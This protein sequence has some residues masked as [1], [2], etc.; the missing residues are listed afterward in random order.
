MTL[1]QSRKLTLIRDI[2][3][4]NAL[5][6]ELLMPVYRQM[7]YVLVDEEHGPQE[8]GKDIVLVGKDPMGDYTYTGVI[9]K[10]G[11]IS[12]ATSPKRSDT[13]ATVANQIVMTLNSGYVC[14]IQQKPVSFQKIVVVT[15]GR[16]SNSAKEE[17]LKTARQHQ[18]Q[19][20][21]FHQGQDLVR[22]VDK[23]LPD[24]Y[25][26][27]SG[28]VSAYISALKAKC[29]RLDE[30]KNISIYKGEIKRILDVFVSP[31]LYR[32]Q[33]VIKGSGVVSS[34]P[35][36][37]SFS[38]L[39][40]RQK[41]LLI[42]GGPGS[43]KSTLLRAGIQR[44]LNLNSPGKELLLPVLARMSD[45][46]TCEGD[47]LEDMLDAYIAQEYGVSDF[48]ISRFLGAEGSR[49]FLFLDGLDEVVDQN[50]RQILNEKVCDF[51][52][53][54]S[55]DRLII[56]SRE[57][58][59]LENE[60]LPEMQR[61]SLL[62]FR[63]K[64]IH[65]FISRWF[66]AD[67]PNRRVMKALEEH[68]LLRKLPNTPLVL[69]L[70][71]IMFDSASYTDV[72]ANLSELY[73]MFVDLLLGKWSLDRR[74]ETLYDANIKEYILMEIAETMHKSDRH[75]LPLSE[76]TALI[77][78]C[79]RRLAVE[80]NPDS[81]LAELTDQTGLI[82]CNDRGELEFRHLSFQEFLVARRYQNRARESVDKE[83]I[84]NFHDP[85][86]ARVVYYYCGLRREN[87]HML[88]DLGVLMRSY[89]LP[90]AL[91]STWEY[92]YLVQSSYL[93]PA[94][95]RVS[96]IIEQLRQYAS[97][98]RQLLNMQV[99]GSSISSL[100]PALLILSMTE[101]FRIYYG[102]SHMATLYA[103]V[104][105]Q[106]QAEPKTFETLL[107]MLLVA[108]ILAEYDCPDYLLDIYDDIRVEPLLL[109]AADFEIRLSLDFD[110]TPEQRGS[111]KRAVKKTRRTIASNA[112]LYRSLLTRKRAG[113]IGDAGSDKLILASGN[114]SA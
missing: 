47:T 111:L 75:G 69:T 32:I 88:S 35:V 42:V 51:A 7:G 90:G 108:S 104:F 5:R 58:S 45:L 95:V 109:L 33:K 55:R 82:A 31:T 24:Y 100:P 107:A 94:E 52:S 74:V 84:S 50:K 60:S 12:N 72:P 40:F 97:H 28:V 113:K 70:L 98:V 14:P 67:A 87:D 102:S 80:V 93:T 39:V 23:Y 89:H 41:H 78:E 10:R 64:Q 110:I 96:C 20:M 54:Y 81:V 63:M 79:G 9:I 71:A 86:W 83:L 114:P 38:S 91:I 2:P 30:L 85:R 68:D 4:E 13:V 44:M 57:F 65:E 1:T 6:T 73:Q 61:W 17:L 27:D 19:T 29:D 53:K 49:V 21:T 36:Y 99:D 103:Q 48:Q 26:F 62:P 11:D 25:H 43:G 101:M 46:A 92:G 56:T 112:Q 3:S 18:F 106:L 76:C 34:Q 77:A 105:S 16:F 37:E 8:R 15:N 59:D 66:G 22:M